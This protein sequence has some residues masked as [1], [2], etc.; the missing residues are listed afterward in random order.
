LVEK[1]AHLVVDKKIVGISDLRDES[2][3]DGIRVVIELKRDASYKK[4]LNNLFKFTELQTTFPVNIVAL[5]DGVPQT[6]SLITILQEYL[7]HRI[8]VVTKRSE[9]ELEQA[10][11]RAHILEGYLIALDHI[12]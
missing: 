4:V 12:D 5:V 8:V 3:R 11:N 9:Y 1:I 2:D 10:R 7:K 6:L